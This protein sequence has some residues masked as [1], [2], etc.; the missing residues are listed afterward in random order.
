[1]TIKFS[2]GLYNEKLV[3][4]PTTS[5]IQ[6]RFLPLDLIKHWKRC[7]LTSTFLA[8]F[9]AYNFSNHKSVLEVMSTILNELIEN[10][11]KYSVRKEEK[12]NVYIGIS[13]N[14]LTIET[15]NNAGEGSANSL[16]ELVKKISEEDTESLFLNQILNAAHQDDNVSGLGLITILK[17]Y[18]TKFGVK[19]TPAK[20]EG[21]YTIHIMVVLNLLDILKELK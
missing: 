18:P 3:G 2:Y 1:M 8:D 10:T 11:T 16:Q 14:S 20:K 17:D 6:M 12:I 9:I 21:I 5:S 7:G 13:D 15:I 19:I 4:D